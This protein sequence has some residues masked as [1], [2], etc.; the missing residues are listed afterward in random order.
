MALDKLSCDVW[1]AVKP[2]N[3]RQLDEESE[4]PLNFDV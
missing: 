3:M 2:V 1:R 4:S